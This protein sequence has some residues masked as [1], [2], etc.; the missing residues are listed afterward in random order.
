MWRLEPDHD[1]PQ[2][3][4]PKTFMELVILIVEVYLQGRE[5]TRIMGHLEKSLQ[6]AKGDQDLSL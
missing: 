6:L 5:D 3:G 1:F 4:I 2:D